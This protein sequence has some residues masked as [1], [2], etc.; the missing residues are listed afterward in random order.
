[1]LLLVGN[2]VTRSK[3]KINIQY[4]KKTN[5]QTYK[6][7]KAKRKEKEKTTTAYS[8]LDIKTFFS[9]IKQIVELQFFSTTSLR[10][11][12]YCL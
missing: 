7:S 8:I 9:S 5:K 11:I 10:L 2:V 3:N 4:K 12:Y 1:V 6:Q